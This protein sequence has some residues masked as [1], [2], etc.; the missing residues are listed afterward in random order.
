MEYFEK[1][2]PMEYSMALT[3]LILCV[4][5]I[6]TAEVAVQLIS[7]FKTCFISGNKILCEDPE[8]NVQYLLR[9]IQFSLH[10]GSLETVRL[11]LE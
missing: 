8:N 10:F 7:Q 3:I 11:P 5:I 9:I 6:E 2:C 1:H 4:F